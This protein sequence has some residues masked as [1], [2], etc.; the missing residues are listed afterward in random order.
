[1]Q[2]SSISCVDER[3]KTSWE[4]GNGAIFAFSYT[5]S[6]LFSLLSFRWC[7]PP[8]LSH[9]PLK[10]RAE[11]FPRN[12]DADKN[13][14]SSLYLFLLWCF[15]CQLHQ[16]WSD[17]GSFICPPL[18]SCLF[19]EFLN[20]SSFHAP[21][22][23]DNIVSC[24]TILVFSH[25]PQNKSKYLSLAFTVVYSWVPT[26]FSFIYVLLFIHLFLSHIWLVH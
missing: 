9:H 5:A 26:P 16:V 18:I 12:T 19:E 20:C 3:K 2:V 11:P 1:M 22:S 10:K 8:S 24:T 23:S 21:T 13:V 15:F 14:L 25:C 4:T 6:Y 7:S 17:L